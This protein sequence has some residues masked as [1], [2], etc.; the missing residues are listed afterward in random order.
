[1][2]LPA[3]LFVYLVMSKQEILEAI[4]K[5]TDELILEEIEQMLKRRVYTPK[6]RET[7]HAVLEQRSKE[8][9]QETG[10]PYEALA[11]RYAG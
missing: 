4:E 1:M 10:I 11:A 7:L 2:H 9:Q 8:A 6:E 5:E 3:P